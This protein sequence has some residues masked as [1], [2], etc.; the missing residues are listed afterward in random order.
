M[1]PAGFRFPQTV[2]VKVIWDLWFFG[3]IGMRIQP[4]RFIKPAFDFEFKSD[5]SAFSK[6]KYVIK[7]I[8]NYAQENSLLAAGSNS[9]SLLSK[10]ASDGV[11]QASFVGLEFTT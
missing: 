10:I 1:V 3:N 9:M 8:C 7:Y 6:A 2:N 4:Y 5:R 11:F